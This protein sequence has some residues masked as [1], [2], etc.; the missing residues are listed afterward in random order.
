MVSVEVTTRV[1]RAREL[2]TLLDD[3]AEALAGGVAERLE[4]DVGVTALAFA[5][6]DR[7]MR[8]ADRAG[9]ADAAHHAE[10]ADDDEVRDRRDQAAGALFDALNNVRSA[11][12][13]VYGSDGERAMGFSG[14]S[15]RAPEQLHERIADLLQRAPSIVMPEPLV[16]VL[17]LDVAGLVHSL[18]VPFERLEAAMKLQLHEDDETEATATNRY[19]AIGELDELCRAGA[20]LLVALAELAGDEPLAD[21]TRRRFNA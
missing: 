8:A 21:R 19:E 6:R 14:P 18:H 2:A 16:K 20:D 12:R 3:Q 1:D 13:S 17:Q 5:V 15:P 10:L 7:L 11:V 4:Q 9:A